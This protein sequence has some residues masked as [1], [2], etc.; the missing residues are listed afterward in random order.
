MN[1]FTLVELLI[2]IGIIAILASFSLFLGFDFYKSQQLETQTEKILQTLRRAQ[3]KS[4]SVEL[5]SSFGVYFDNNNKKYILFKGN[6]YSP[7]D[8]Y[9]EEFDL[10]TI[11]NLSGLSEIVFSK[12]EGKPNLTG[13]IILTVNSKQR[14][15]NINEIGKIEIQ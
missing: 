1:S 8:P 15:I 12:S 4:M 11:I 3:A 6:S 5:D 2:V 14:I 13:N 7:Q 10:P 9:N